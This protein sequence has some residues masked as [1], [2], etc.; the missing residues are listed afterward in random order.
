M[1][2]AYAYTI[3]ESSSIKVRACMDM[4]EPGGY[5]GQFDLTEAMRKSP[6]AFKVYQEI[7]GEYPK[8]QARSDF[9]INFG[10]DLASRSP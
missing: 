4:E 2:R 8:S 3:Y 5:A 7:L 1:P 9:L 10:L 6:E